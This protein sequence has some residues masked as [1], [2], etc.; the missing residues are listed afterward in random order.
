VL[1]VIPPTFVMRYGSLT[2]FNTLASC[3]HHKADDLLCNR[4]CLLWR[5]LSTTFSNIHIYSWL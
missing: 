1:G 3:K 5:N 2:V 4:S